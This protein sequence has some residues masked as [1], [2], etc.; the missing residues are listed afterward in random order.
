MK[1]F[2][3][4]G[5]R[6]L[7]FQ[8]KLTLSLVALSFVAISGVGVTLT[9]LSNQQAARAL[10]DKA[11][12]YAM[13]ISPQLEP[14]V[15]FNDR[16]TARELFQSF[17]GD[18]DVSGLSVYD[19]GGGLIDGY[20]TFPPAMSNSAPPV[21]IAGHLVVLA[22]IISAEGPRGRL[23][24]SLSTAPLQQFRRRS[25]LTAVMIGVAALAVAAVIA[26]ALARSVAR[27]VGTIAD[28]AGR[29]AAGD[30]DQP[31][32]ATGADDEIGRLAGAFNIMVGELKKQF[33][34]RAQMEASARARLESV[35][36]RRT[37]ELQE[38]R[39]Q[40][41]LV[42]ESTNAI[43]FTY[44]PATERFTY[45]GP[46]AEKRLDYPL[47]SWKEPGFLF[48]LLPADEVASVRARI[49]SAE[50]GSEFEFEC[51]VRTATGRGVQLRWVVACGEIKGERCL[52]GLV[53]DISDQRRLESDL[54][55]AQK[56]ESVG[57]LAA[58]V[59]H[60]INTPIQFV[61]D[62]VQFL[63]EGMTDVVAVLAK[64]RA[65]RAAVVAGEPSLEA[66]AAV[67]QAEV[68]V[69]L[70]YLID[71]MPSA[72]DRSLD[73]LDRVATIV[74]SMKEFAH[75]DQKDMSSVDLNQAIQS[76]LVIARNEYKYVADVETDFGELPRVTCHA[77]D[78]NQA[79][80][81]IVV[82][83]AHAIG[84]VVAGTDAKGTISVSTRHDGDF[85][86]I[87]I[88]DTGGGIPDAI[89]DRIFDP[90]F[91]TKEV[92]KG[93]GQGLA[94][95]RSVIL[96]KHGGEFA[97]ESRGGQGTTFVIRLP[98]DGRKVRATVAA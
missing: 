58:G 18:A 46:Q 88:G 73:G 82:N 4:S 91:T 56:L 90:F 42:A 85:A 95:A 67:A 84:D 61:S 5:L 43:P 76:T 70:D 28:A 72:I 25:I 51:T 94:I 26:M 13:L 7:S 31:E 78:V 37:S 62:S 93:T 29:V 69:D 81:N 32:I 40:Y 74:K 77:G 52:R 48:A 64:Y 53:L 45:V 24:L 2:R 75:P 63:R 10:R 20:R 11:T 49:D 92:G 66:A 96:E 35:V 87:R 55:Q 21:K 6:S 44:L 19:S 14:V 50:P 54:A 47:D 16:L 98:I 83:A 15:A 22:P 1:T 65:L 89:R 23:F 9:T 27:R 34:D 57:R 33:V 3:R 59:A 39:E 41:R 8:A 86:V 68:D 79:V 97:F 71:Q 80:L 12:R 38:S 17:G 30:L 60:E 36:E